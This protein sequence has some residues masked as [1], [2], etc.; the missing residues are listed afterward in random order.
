MNVQKANKLTR[1]N[2]AKHSAKMNTNS[3]S[4]LNSSWLNHY[5]F[6]IKCWKVREER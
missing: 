6:K 5:V 1:T 3:M 4:H 2:S